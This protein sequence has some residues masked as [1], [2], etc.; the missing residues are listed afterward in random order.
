MI[1]DAKGQL[2]SAFA[3]TTPHD[4]T[5]LFPT[6]YYDNRVAADIGAGGTVGFYVNVN[7]TAVGATNTTIFYLIGN[8]TDPTFASNNLQINISQTVAVAT[9]VKGF[10]LQFKVRPGFVARYYTLGVALNV[11]DLSAGKFD[12][13]LVND[14]FQTAKTSYPAGYSITAPA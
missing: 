12:A 13:W 11:A 7:T 8:L 2:A 6:T 1:L 3:P 5:I 4:G 10:E 9:L 14:D